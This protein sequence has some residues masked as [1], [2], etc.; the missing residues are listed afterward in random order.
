MVVNGRVVAAQ[1]MTEQKAAEVF[2]TAKRE[3]R[4]AMLVA[5]ERSNLFTLKLG[6]L[7]PGEVVV[8][9]LAYVQELD[10]LHRTVALRIPFAPGVRY[11]PGKSLL[12]SNVS[13]RATTGRTEGRNLIVWREC[14]QVR[15]PGK[16]D[17]SRN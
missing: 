1:A 12:R 3:G 6:N 13:G 15:T 4:R 5:Q 14:E 17:Q 16:P 2:A 10:R 11:I 9:R 7:Q 8:I